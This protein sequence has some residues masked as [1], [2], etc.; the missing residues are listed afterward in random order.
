MS[1]EINQ[2]VLEYFEKNSAKG[3]KKMYP[4]DVAK[5]MEESFPRAE[6]KKAI[7]ELLDAEKLKYWSS[8]STTFVMLAKDWEEQQGKDEG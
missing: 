6:V 3:K 8:G 7:Q 4:K 2:A 1:E 5:S